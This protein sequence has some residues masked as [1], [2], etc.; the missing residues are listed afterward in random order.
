MKGLA[1]DGTRWPS[2][3]RFCFA[4]QPDEPAL[5]HGAQ[6]RDCSKSFSIA[7]IHS[8]RRPHRPRG[9]DRLVVVVL[10]GHRRAE[11]APATAVLSLPVP[12]PS[13]TPTSDQPEI[14]APS[15][16]RRVA[17]L[18]SQRLGCLLFESKSSSRIPGTVSKKDLKHINQE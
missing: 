1:R 16:R 2:G 6:H 5:L 11:V 12:L 14:H 3:A 7:S 18:S 17:P 9:P 8:I 4:S 13:C 10:T 15:I